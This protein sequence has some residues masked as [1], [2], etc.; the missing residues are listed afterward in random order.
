MRRGWPKNRQ[1]RSC[2]ALRDREASRSLVARLCPSR[3]DQ[4]IRRDI[5]LEPMRQTLGQLD[6]QR[7]PSFVDSVPT[8]LESP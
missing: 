3:H 5:G 6:S 2:R 1:R 8:I 4:L 7:L